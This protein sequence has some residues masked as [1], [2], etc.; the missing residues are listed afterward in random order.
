MKADIPNI[1]VGEVA[2]SS[3]R[4]KNHLRQKSVK[5]DKDKKEENDHW[6]DMMFELKIKKKLAPYIEQI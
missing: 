3:K 1:Q 5:F 6:L 4:V 2:S